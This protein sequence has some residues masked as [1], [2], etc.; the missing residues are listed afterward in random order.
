[1][2]ELIDPHDD[3]YTNQ[4]ALADADAAFYLTELLGDDSE[5]VAVRAARVV[6][7]MA[8]HSALAKARLSSGPL[9]GL[10]SNVTKVML[11]PVQDDLIGAGAAAR[12]VPLLASPTPQVSQAALE[13]LTALSIYNHDGKMAFLAGLVDA[14]AAGT[15][16]ALLEALEGLVDGLDCS[17]GS[18][19][20]DEALALLEEAAAAATQALTLPGTVG[21]RAVAA[22]GAVCEA[23]PALN[24]LSP[25]SAL[26][27]APAALARHLLFGQIQAQDAAARALRHLAAG[28][29]GLLGPDGEL[30]PHAEGMARVLQA[31]IQRSVQQDQEEE[32]R[33][34]GRGSEG[35]EEGPTA[36]YL[37]PDAGTAA[38]EVCFAEEAQELLDAIVK[39][40]PD[41]DVGPVEG[42]RPK[43][44]CC[45]M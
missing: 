22:V 33:G 5:A 19:N 26:A 24:A 35:E 17:S 27:A 12:L 3:V 42:W 32:E 10:E 18:S 44:T 37:G 7:A 34:G 41:L 36:P 23:A 8:D 45:I 43:S 25:G 11:N 20:A 30:G 29:P 15:Q 9:L 38:E 1:M 28:N 40:N 21:E 39:A 2:R 6:A 4:K 31:L 14:L 13:A 16:A